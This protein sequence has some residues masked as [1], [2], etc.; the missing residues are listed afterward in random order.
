[1]DYKFFFIGL[2][3]ILLTGFLDDVTGF[4][5]TQKFIGEFL[6]AISLVLGG[7]LIEA[8]VSPDGTVLSLGWFSYPFTVLWIVLVINSLNLMDGLDG[9]ASGISLFACLAFL[10]IATLSGNIFLIVLTIALAGGILGFLRYNWH[11]ASIFMGDIGSLQLGFL[12]A[13]LSIETLKI[14]GSH[15]ISFLTALVILGVPLTDTLISF[16]RRLGEGSH[17]FRADKEHVHHRFLNLGLSHLQTVKLIHVLAI[18]YALTGVMMTFYSEFTATILFIMAFSF[19]IFWAWRLGYV[20]TRTFITFGLSER[21]TSAKI[22]PPL[23]W[24]RLWHQ[25]IILVGDVIAINFALYLTFWFKFQSGMVQPITTRPMEDFVANPVFLLFTLGWV[26]LFWLNGLYHMPWDISRF[27]KIVKVGKVITFGVIVL[28]LL[29]ADINS[30]VSQSQISTL[31]FYWIV[32]FTAVNFFRLLII[33]V[34]KTF[35]I[36][37]YSFKNT[38]VLGTTRKAKQIIRDVISNPHML[39]KIVGIIDNRYRKEEFEG[40]P[41]LGRF[42]DLEEIIFNRK[43][44]EVIIAL[45]RTSREVLMDIIGTCDRLQIVVKTLPEL[46]EIVTGKNQNI[47]GHFLVRVFPERMVLWQ[48]VIKKIVDLIFSTLAIIFLSPVYLILSILIKLKF[49]GSVFIK[50]RILGKNGQVFQMLYFR[51]SSDK[52]EPNMDYQEQITK[53]RLTRFGKFLFIRNLYKLPQLFNVFIGDMSIAGPRPEAMDWYRKYQKKLRLLHRRVLVRP[54]FTGLAQVKYRYEI[55]QKIMQER[56]KYDIF[57]VDNMSLNL[58]LRIMIRSSI[59][60]FIKPKRNSSKV[61]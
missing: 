3:I 32:M 19:S 24:N 12:L 47:A 15:Q 13:F 36:L 21:E 25:I 41:I 29:T 11:P 33:R 48:W 1:L 43:I 44:V 52:F 5:V 27:D 23:H 46:K 59:L 20:E 56:L 50:K 40:T 9:L 58:D 49:T 4:R 7:C 31:I 57:Y 61:A 45:D 22:R 34:E 39:Y 10:A 60:F 30:I 8:F 28:G 17:P 54:G 2:F 42:E 55:S 16:F 51:V 35:H 53:L 38:L 6:G 14:A 37:E 26:S 18:F